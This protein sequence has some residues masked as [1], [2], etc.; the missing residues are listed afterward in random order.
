MLQGLAFSGKVDGFCA[1]EFGFTV[2]S[3][4]NAVVSAFIGLNDDRQVFVQGK[5]FNDRGN[6]A[7][8]DIATSID[9]FVILGDGDKD[10]VFFELNCGGSFRLVDFDSGFFNEDGGDNKKDEQDE[11]HVDHGR[12]VDLDIILVV[13]G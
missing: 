1:G 10:A 13:G 11:N 2:N 9:D 3:S 8:T 7:Y 4:K 12:E 5:A 6:T